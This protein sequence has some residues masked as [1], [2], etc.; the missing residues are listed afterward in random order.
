MN[1]STSA[2]P[3]PLPVTDP[4]WFQPLPFTVA[5]PEFTH[6]ITLALGWGRNPKGP[7]PVAA[8]NYLLPDAVVQ[9]YRG[10]PAAAMVLVAVDLRSG[11]VFANGCVGPDRPPPV[12]NAKALGAANVHAPSAGG[13]LAVDLGVQLG[14]PAQAASYRVFV[15]LDEWVSAVQRLDL[16]EA[17]HR[18]R[19]GVGPLANTPAAAAARPLPA[20]VPGAGLKLMAQAERMRGMWSG[21]GHEPVVLLGLDLAR[22]S[23]RWER[24]APAGDPLS[25]AGLMEVVADRFM[26]SPTQPRGFVLSAGASAA[27]LL[28][29]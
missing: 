5:L 29:A 18:S 9:R 13:Y 16:P 17:A 24:L 15:W 2:A 14:L 21:Q 27:G 28:M 25:D 26:G 22:R 23:L 19:L 1:S 12:F 6:G 20:P 3:A 10:N 7:T 8:M 4:V 11:E